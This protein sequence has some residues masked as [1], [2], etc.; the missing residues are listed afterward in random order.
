MIIFT[1][2]C[3]NYAH[4]ARTLAQSVKENIPDAKFFVCLTETEKPEAMNSPYFDE[5]ILSKDMWNGNFN[6]FIYKH[7]IVEASTSVKGQFFRF[8]MQEHPEEDK[9]IYLDPDC[10]VYA[11]FVELKKLLEPRPFILFHRAILI[12]NCLPQPMEYII[13]G[14]WPL[15][16]VKR[17]SGL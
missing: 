4:K 10:Y 9:F 7:S 1:S 6:Q 15:I 13:W 17:Q 11:D 2:I 3:T 8:L 14:F 16:T 12:W 5:V